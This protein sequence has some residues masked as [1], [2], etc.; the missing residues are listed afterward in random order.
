MIYLAAV[1]LIITSVAVYLR[2]RSDGFLSTLL[3]LC[4]AAVSGWVAG[5]II[6]VGARIGMWSIPFFNGGDSR[7]TFDGTLQVILT[8]S[9]FGIG[10]G[11]IYEF[12][13]RGIPGTRG[14][15]FG[16][17]ITL[18]TVYP[19][20]AA[21]LQQINFTPSL[22]PAGAVSFFFVA[23]MFVPFGMALE[24]MIGHYHEIRGYRSLSHDRVG[25]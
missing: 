14:I 20:S 1:A 4:A 24:L 3:D 7:F 17:V 22:L 11:A 13:F 2:S 15:L 12:I 10:L 19:L 9:L 21:A 16:L 8:F 23:L 6:G 18:V 5:L 25:N